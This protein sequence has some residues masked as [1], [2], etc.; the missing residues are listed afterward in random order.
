MV[1]D[2]KRDATMGD[3]NAGRKLHGQPLLQARELEDLKHESR[4]A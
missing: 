3:L 1:L 2:W 4:E